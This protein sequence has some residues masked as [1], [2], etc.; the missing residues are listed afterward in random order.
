M[1]ISNID[2]GRVT[3]GLTVKSQS[4]RRLLMLSLIYFGMGP[5]TL[6]FKSLWQ[7]TSF[8]WKR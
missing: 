2:T 5:S 1:S 8:P 7:T 3:L 6:Q 4:G